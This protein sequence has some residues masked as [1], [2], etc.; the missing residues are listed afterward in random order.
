MDDFEQYCW[1]IKGLLLSYMATIYLVFS[2]NKTPKSSNIYQDF[3][4]M[5]NAHLR[6]HSTERRN[7]IK[8]AI[9]LFAFESRRHVGT[10]IIGAVLAADDSC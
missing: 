1:P 3:I 4:A 2:G 5:W 10:D 8:S 9:D 7:H 6:A